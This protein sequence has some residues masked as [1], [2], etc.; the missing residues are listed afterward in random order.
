[1][2]TLGTLA[3]DRTMEHIGVVLPYGDADGVPLT[4]VD[5]GYRVSAPGTVY[6]Y[7]TG[8]LC[9]LTPSGFGKYVACSLF[10]LVPGVTYRILVKPYTAAGPLSTQTALIT[11]RADAIP[12]RATLTPTQTV[13]TSEELQAAWT[14]APSGAV[15]QAAPGFYAAPR[16]KRT[17]PITL[18]AEHPAV[19]SVSAETLAVDREPDPF[20]L[21]YLFGGMT[22]PAGSP[23]AEDTLAGGWMAGG[24][25]VWYRD[26]G[27]AN[28]RTLAWQRIDRDG[29]WQHQKRGPVRHAVHWNADDL[30]TAAEWSTMLLENLSYNHGFYQ[31]P[32]SAR[33]YLRLQGDADPNDCYLWFSSGTGTDPAAQC[34][35]TLDAP[36]CRVSGFAFRG[37]TNDVRLTINAHRAVVDGCSSDSSHTFVLFNGWRSD[38]RQIQDAVVQDCVARTTDR[39][40]SDA[41][42]DP[43]SWATVKVGPADP[44]SPEYLEGGAKNPHYPYYVYNGVRGGKPCAMSEHS[45]ITFRQGVKN[46]IIRRC[47][48]EG[49]FNAVGGA[50]TRPTSMDSIDVLDCLARQIADNGWEPES[51]VRNWRSVR[52]RVEHA[53]TGFASS[54][55]GG[56]V[57]AR[58]CVNWRCNNRLLAP[59]QR[60]VPSLVYTGG[61]AGW[62]WGHSEPGVIIQSRNTIWNDEPRASGRGDEAY[63]RS[64]GGGGTAWFDDGMIVRCSGIVTKGTHLRTVTNSI[65][66]GAEADPATVAAIDAALTDPTH[67]DL[68]PVAGGLLDGKG[69]RY[70]LKLAVPPMAPP[71]AREDETVETVEITPNSADFGRTA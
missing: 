48:F 65:E 15:V 68:T 16:G 38:D 19:R 22:A 9:D 61:A 57:Y 24:N 53:N 39:V 30:A 59:I 67:G 52:C 20:K 37:L 40:K 46:A 4:R 5:V 17:A 28:V 2:A 18:V 55:Q 70:H 69:A 63:D 35:F 27:L 62:K 26:V 36:D 60:G 34:G 32:G 29:C 7:A 25:G 21:S 49:G 58:D 11:T 41:C 64:S 71:D 3:L 6:A 14:S 56:P 66:A 42:P 1:M 54:L 12:D 43:V 23:L 44:A 10:D 50:G 8:R 33:M 31:E 47:V 13:R 51:I 45:F